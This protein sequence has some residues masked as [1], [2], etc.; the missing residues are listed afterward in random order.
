MSRPRF[1]WY[2]IVKK[3]V[4]RYPGLKAEESE[5]AVLYTAAIEKAIRETESLDNGE[6]RMQA[7]ELVLFKK[8]H[9][10]DGAAMEVNYSAPSII[11]W[12]NKF[13]NEVGRNVGY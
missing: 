5:M 12:I 1:Y 13:I 7:I 11:K 8:T 4:M 2:G 10:I 9:T 6:C 3:M